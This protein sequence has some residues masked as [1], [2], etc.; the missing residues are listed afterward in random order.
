MFEYIIENN[1][2][3]ITGI[4]DKSLEHITIVIHYNEL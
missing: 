2:V 3:T 4:I 1:E